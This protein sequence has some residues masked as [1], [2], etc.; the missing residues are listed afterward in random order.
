[1]LKSKHTNDSAI[2]VGI[3]EAGRGCLWGPLY[4]GAVIWPP[5]N[6][7]NEEQLNV[8]KRIKDSKKMT[9]KRRNEVAALIKDLAI[10][11][12]VG[13]V[14]AKE[15]DELGMTKSNQLAFTRALDSLSVEPERLLIDG[16]L[17]I[18]EPP[19]SMVEQIV[20]PEADGN[21]LSVAAASIIA[22]TEHD[23]WVTSFCDINTNIAEQYDLPSNKGYGTL[24]HRKGILEHGQHSEHRALFLRKI[25]AKVQTTGDSILESTTD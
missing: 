24:K 4:A 8:S 5:E 15:I 3:D 1:M 13:V 16:I 6:E 25:L 21:Y 17:S 18:Y 14:S 11:W 9:P 20:E 12:G 23:K 2:E 7:M 19:W 22:K 10:D